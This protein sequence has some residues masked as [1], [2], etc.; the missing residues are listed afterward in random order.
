MT[1]FNDISTEMLRNFYMD[2]DYRKQWDKTV[3]EHNQL[4]AYESEGVEV[5]RTVKKFPL[6]RPRE[7][8]LSWKLW[9]G[10]DKTFY[11]F[12]KVIY[13]FVVLLIMMLICAFSIL[14]SFMQIAMPTILVIA[15]IYGCCCRC[16]FPCLFLFNCL[17]RP[18]T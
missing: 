15:F 6:L 2:N 3:I 13:P 14:I 10:R 9:E 17:W 12:M 11:C 16:M 8:V 5:G 1:I 7:Y 18:V 4:Q